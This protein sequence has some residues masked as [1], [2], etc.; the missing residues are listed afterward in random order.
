LAPQL[1][2]F[3]EQV[4]LF[5]IPRSPRQLVYL[6]MGS[7]LCFGGWQLGRIVL[8]AD[9]P[10]HGISMWHVLL[11]ILAYGL[12]LAQDL[13]VATRGPESERL[14]WRFSLEQLRD[15]IRTP[16]RSS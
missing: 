12:V 10:F 11:S 9:N 8:P 7:W 16:R 1:P 3:Y 6:V 4:L 2:Y 5:L 15:Q 13:G 14:S